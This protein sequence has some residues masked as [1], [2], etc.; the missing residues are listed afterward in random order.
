MKRSAIWTAAGMMMCTMV[1]AQVQPGTPGW[2]AFDMPGLDAPAGGVADRSGLTVEAAGTRGFVTIRNG[3]FADGSGARLKLFGTNVTGDSCFPPAETSKRLAVRLRQLGFNCLRL[4]FM[5]YSWRTGSI[6]ENN[7]EGTL[8]EESLQALDR[9]IADCAA[10]GIYI[11]LNLHVAREYPGQPRGDG[12]RTFRMGKTLDRWYPPY[13][14]MLKNYSAALLNRVNPHLG[15]RYAEEP[16]IACIE[17]NNEN[18]LIADLREDYRQLPEPMLEVFTRQWTDWLQQKYKTTAT[19]RTAWEAEV[20]PLG[21]DLL[22]DRE[23]IVENAGGAESEL[24]VNPEPRE[25]RWNA[26]RAGTQGWNLQMQC[27]K[28][29]VPPGRYT[30]HFAARS[31]TESTVSCSLMVDAAPWSTLGLSR[32]TKLGKEWT[33]VVIMGDVVSS[34]VPALLRLNLSLSNKPGV[35]EFRDFSLRPGGGRGLPE[36]ESLESGVGIPP[37]D[38]MA[39]AMNDYFAFLIDTEMDTTREIVRFLKQDLG[40]RMPIADTQVSYGG[41]GGVR[42]ETRIC[43]YTDIHGYW[44][45]PNYTRNEKGRVTDFRI[46]NTTQVASL[47]GGTLA[48]LAI[49]RVANRPLSVSEYN[50]PAPNDHGAELFPLLAF[51]ASV[52]D[53]D[54][55]YSY[56]YRDFGKDYEN[57]ALKKYFHLIGRANVLVH[58]PASAMLFRGGLLNAY[59]PELTLILPDARVPEFARTRK[60]LGE[61]WTALGTDLRATWLRGTVLSLSEEASE[62]GFTGEGTVSGPVL[63]DRSGMVSWEPECPEGA[64]FSLN[65]PAVRFLIGHVGGRAFEVGDAHFAVDPRPWP[66]DKAAYACISLVALDGLPIRDSRRMLLAA[67]ARTEN[68]DMKWNETRTSL[69]QNGWGE[70][71]TLSESVPL[72]LNLPGEPVTLIRLDANGHEDGILG[73]ERREVRLDATANSLWFFLSRP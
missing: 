30:W 64:W 8:S 44:E 20:I 47:S 13:V 62:P 68:R 41:A 59:P 22:A 7:D 48:N 31:E 25:W 58:A 65:A 60:R 26:T 49:H 14:A 9:F 15:R 21:K 57:T 6:W 4:H 66:G 17:I 36:N 42:R 11:D 2:F 1:S 61:L 69:E 72:T 56:T 38:A 3:H 5:D 40:C 10:Q 45:H 46:P 71:P 33:D 37:D 73:R 24:S 23:W 27:K 53:W 51:M 29:T 35:V 19:L 18:T 52:Q 50:T 28:L 63:S 67:S 55:L 12:S 54:A 39:T 32:K 34:P 43:D 16:A 70:G